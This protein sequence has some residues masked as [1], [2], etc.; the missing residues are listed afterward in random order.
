MAVSAFQRNQLLGYLALLQKWNATYN[1]TA[2]RE[3]DRMLT[4]HIVDSLAVVTPLQRQLK[5]LAASRLVDAGS[6][7]GLPGVVLAIMFPRLQIVCVDSV[8]KKASFVRQ[9]AAELSMANLAAIHSRLEAVGGAQAE[10]I[11]SRAFATLAD[12]VEATESLLLPDGVWMAMKGKHPSAE[13]DVLPTTV[14]LFHV[15]QLTVPGLD[16]E[17][18]VVW[19]R[20]NRAL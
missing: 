5:T 2:I 6:G 14:R 7:A 1:L 19:L 3:P 8:G 11:T 18:C 17:R 16:A 9:V 10:V 4:H 12:M 13:I 15:E 20:R